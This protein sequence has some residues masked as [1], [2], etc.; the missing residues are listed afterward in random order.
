MIGNNSL[1]SISL[2]SQFSSKKFS[3]ST[4]PTRMTRSGYHLAAL[5]MG[6]LVMLA[7]SSKGARASLFPVEQSTLESESRSLTNVLSH[8]NLNHQQNPLE[9][10]APKYYKLNELLYKSRPRSSV[11]EDAD[12]YVNPSRTRSDDQTDDLRPLEVGASQ[13]GSRRR[14]SGNEDDESSIDSLIRE[15]QQEKAIGRRQGDKTG[16]TYEQ[17]SARRDPGGKAVMMDNGIG[18]YDEATIQRKSTN[19]IDEDL[20]GLDEASAR[21]KNQSKFHRGCI[22]QRGGSSP[23]RAN[24]LETSLES[25]LI[26]ALSPNIALGYIV[27]T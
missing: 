22:W 10:D 1:F 17:D 26:N 14:A 24:F 12:G 27:I 25:S 18:A 5:F 2:S 7:S 23:I 4:E 8:S 6:S 19:P 9:S 16:V 20:S 21:L 15:M 11:N 3:N 13:A